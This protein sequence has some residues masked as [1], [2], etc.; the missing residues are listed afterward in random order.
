MPNLITHGLSALMEACNMSADADTQ[1]DTLMESFE[2]SIDDDII[3]AL[4]DGKLEDSVENDMEG[5]G[6]GDDA[7]MEKLLAKIP[8]SDESIKEEIGALSESVLP[9]DMTEGVT[10]EN[11]I[12]NIE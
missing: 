10:M 6:I 12:G 7:E 11:W 9:C 1:N 3:D 8:P 5:N 2:S 4:T